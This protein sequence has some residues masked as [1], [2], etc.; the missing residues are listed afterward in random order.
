VIPAEAAGALVARLED[1]LDVYT[2]LDDPQ[3]PPVCLDEQPVPLIG[4][5]RRPLAAQPGHPQRFDY[6]YVRNG[7]ANIF[8]AG[9]PLTGQRQV[10]VRD[11]RTAAD[12]ARFI[13][14]LVDLHYPH[15]ERIVLVLDHRNTHP[16]GSRY[17]TFPPTEARR[18]ANK[19]EI[20]Y[21]PVQGSWLDMAEI[22]LSVLSRPCLNRRLPD[23][24]P[25]DAEVAAWLQ[26][27]NTLGAPLHWRFTT[28]DARIK[29]HRLYPSIS[30]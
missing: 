28:A 30:E 10:Q 11:R 22:E 13:R 17:A 8:L 9:E 7:V 6:E 24:A 20:H 14:L 25:L 21:P 26:R 3:R 15:A 19:L 18:L 16:L 4:E 23:R 12:G 27:R 2:R 1:V 5:T 29:L